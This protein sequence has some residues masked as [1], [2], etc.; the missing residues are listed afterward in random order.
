MRHIPNISF[1]LIGLLT[2]ILIHSQTPIFCCLP[3]D[4]LYVN[5]I[6]DLILSSESENINLPT[7]VN[8]SQ[9]I[10][11]PNEIY[12]QEGYTGGGT[13]SC[14]SIPTVYYCFTYEIYW[15]KLS[16]IL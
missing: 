5:S 12:N 15:N 9:E 3:D 1:L 10:Y 8:N 2:P 13:A 16:Q 11:F 7:E 6:P 14:A 4:P